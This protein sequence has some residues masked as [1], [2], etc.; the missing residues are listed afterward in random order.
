M[1]YISYG[2]P[3]QHGVWREAVAK[4][5]MEP[6]GYI[7]LPE[8]LSWLQRRPVLPSSAVH[9]DLHIWGIPDTL[10]S[11]C[12]VVHRAPRCGLYSMLGTAPPDWRVRRRRWY[13]ISP[14]WIWLHI[15]HSQINHLENFQK[16]ISTTLRSRNR[17]P[18]PRTLT[19]P[20]TKGS[21]SSLYTYFKHQKSVS[22]IFEL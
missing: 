16:N 14:E 7:D 22:S 17:C 6:P 10:L 9:L 19:L 4:R 13:L 1:P 21:N 3:D 2:D 15:H 20:V 5:W 11:K 8:G 12:L 18:P